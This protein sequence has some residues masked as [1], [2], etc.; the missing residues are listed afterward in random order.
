[1][2]STAD[3]AQQPSASAAVQ[4]HHRRHHWKTHGPLFPTPGVV[5]VAVL[6]VV[7]RLAAVLLACVAIAMQS[8]QSAHMRAAM[9]LCA[10]T[11]VLCFAPCTFQTCGHTAYAAPLVLALLIAAQYI[12]AS[13]CVHGLAV[14]RAYF[15]RGL[16]VCALLTNACRRRHSGCHEVSADDLSHLTMFEPSS[17]RRGSAKSS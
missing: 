4:Q 13:G 1:M 14:I 7:R 2:S 15:Q 6:A 9:T 3:P 8:L 5:V 17:P 16:F 10:S 12:S 11:A